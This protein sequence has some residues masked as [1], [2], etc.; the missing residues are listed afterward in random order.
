MHR[1]DSIDTLRGFAAISVVVYHVIEHF[2]WDSFPSSGPLLWFRIGGF[3]VD[4]FFVISGLVITLSA[5]EGIDRHGTVGFRRPFAER[6]LRRIVPLY[7]L[8]AAL[9]VVLFAPS[10]ALDAW[11]VISHLLFVHNLSVST[12]GSIDGANW[13]LGTEMQFYALVLLLAPWLRSVSPWLLGS[14][15]IL[16]AWAWRAWA[17]Y[18]VGPEGGAHPLFIATTQLPGTLDLFGIGILLARFIRSERGTAFFSGLTPRGV[19]GVVVAAA[20]IVVI[21]LKLYWLDATYW[22]SPIMVTLFRTVVAIAAGSVLFAACCLNCPLWLRVTTPLRYL[23]TIS[24]G[25]YLWHLLIIESLKHVPGMDGPTALP[26]VLTGTLVLAA[27]SWHLLEQPLVRRRANV[28][29]IG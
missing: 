17:F 7:Y 6:R 15:L 1:F 28:V 18:V 26:I 3:G 24:Y 9:Y 2:D 25:I 19:A 13:S 8:T 16:A 21:A 23:G 20:A 22:H 12:H 10:L 29:T 14:T 27:I 5:F 11:Q 4:L